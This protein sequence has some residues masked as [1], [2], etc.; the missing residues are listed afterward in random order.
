[1]KTKKKIVKLTESELK[2]TISESVKKVLKEKITFDDGTVDHE[3]FDKVENEYSIVGMIKSD[4]NPIKQKFK[5]TN[6]DDAIAQAK[7]Y[8]V[9]FTS[10]GEKDVDIFYVHS[11]AY[12]GI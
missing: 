11:N 12:D 3:W 2:K 5:A 1:M 8:F 4:M 9:R 7:K 6:I 10:M